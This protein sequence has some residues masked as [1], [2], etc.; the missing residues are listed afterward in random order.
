M[1][2]SPK[3]KTQVR[4]LWWD[5][6]SKSY[7]GWPTKNR[8]GFCNWINGRPVRLRLVPVERKPKRRKK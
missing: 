1:K 4:W 5:Y 7:Q 3:P 6:E 8:D 2:S